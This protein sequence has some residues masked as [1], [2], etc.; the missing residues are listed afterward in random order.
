MPV[1]GITRRVVTLRQA[2][3]WPML[4]AIM[5][6]TT[7]N[8]YT[9]SGVYPIDSGNYTTVVG[10]FQNSKSAYGTFDQGGNVLEWIDWNNSFSNGSF[11][12]FRGASYQYYYGDMLAHH[13]GNL[14]LVADEFSSTG[15]RVVSSVPE[16]G[17]IIFLVSGA[18]AALFW[19]RR[20][21]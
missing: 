13:R 19:R 11:R 18:V 1:T 8:Y 14:G 5:P 12:G 2:A 9:G 15:F 10:E 4:L 7:R 3:T 16:P 20:W 17:S 6:T 21:S